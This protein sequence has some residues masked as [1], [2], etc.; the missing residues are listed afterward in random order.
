MGGITL[1]PVHVAET[2]KF[3]YDMPQEVNIREIDIAATAQDA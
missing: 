1:N 2:V 3:I